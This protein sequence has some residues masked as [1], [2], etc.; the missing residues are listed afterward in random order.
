M[1]KKKKAIII[2][3]QNIDKTTRERFEKRK[4]VLPVLALCIQ[5]QAGQHNMSDVRVYEINSTG[6]NVLGNIKITW[7][8]F[9]L[10]RMFR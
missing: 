5:R 6:A 4:L 9:G 1:K 2:I 3:E 8:R 7:G 10:D